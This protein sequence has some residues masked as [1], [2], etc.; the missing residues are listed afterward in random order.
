MPA[1]LA[2]RWAV[3]LCQ[4]TPVASPPTMSRLYQWGF[5]KFALLCPPDGAE[6]AAILAAGLPRDAV[7]LPAIEAPPD[8]SVLAWLGRALPAVDADHVFL[9]DLDA[10]PDVDV[11]G[12]FHLHVRRRA[13]ATLWSRRAVAVPAAAGGPRSTA[14]VS[15]PIDAAPAWISRADLVRATTGRPLADDFLGALAR[16]GR[17]TYFEGAGPWEAPGRASHPGAGALEAPA[18]GAAAA[19][20]LATRSSYGTRYVSSIDRMRRQIR[21]KTVLPHQVEVQPGPMSTQLCWMKCPYCYGVSATDTGE[22]LPIDRYE[23]VLRQIADGGVTKIIF[24]GYA[25]DPLAFRDIERLIAVSREYGQ[26]VGIHTKALRVS[27]TLVGLIA[28]RDVAPLSYLSVSVDAGTNE[29]YNRVHGMPDSRAPL[30]DRVVANLTR[31]CAARRATGAPLD[32]TATYLLNGH[33]ASP[34]EV[35]TAIEDL[36][37][38]GVDLIRFTFPQTPRGYVPAPGDRDV[39]DR[40][41]VR[42]I[43]GRLA[44]TIAAMSDDRCRVVIMDVDEQYHVYDRPRTLP[45]FARFVFPTIGFDGYLSHCSESCAPHFRPIALGDLTRRDFWDVFYDYDSDRLGASLAG[46]A[47]LMNE[48]G[49]RCSRKEHV[50]NEG[51]A[52]AGLLHGL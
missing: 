4:G 43:Y 37:R 7:A 3:V 33:N 6:A 23:E 30:Y 42:T 14:V 21:E 13:G 22:R 50:L 24:A 32:V 26:I 29:T 11:L 12:M 38:A 9:T 1:F 52:A 28:A 41:A 17:L 34:A 27:D 15:S 25:T 18:G 47:V 35:F 19:S 20:D 46:G 5:R 48:L 45:C 49:C 39:P 2:R 10:P 31:V 44:E 16:E 36:K 40:A 51:L 8:G